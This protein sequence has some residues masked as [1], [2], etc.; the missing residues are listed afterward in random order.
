MYDEES[1]SDSDLNWPRV[2]KRKRSSVAKKSSGNRRTS[3]T[4]HASRRKR[5][6][7][8]PSALQRV[9]KR[10]KDQASFPVMCGDKQ[11]VLHKAKFIKKT[12][13]KCIRTQDAWLTPKDFLERNKVDGN[14]RR[15][16]R[17]RDKPLGELIMNGELELHS[18][19]CKCPICTRE[20]LHEVSAGVSQVQVLWESI[21]AVS[22]APALACRESLP[23]LVPSFGERGDDQIGQ[24]LLQTL[25][26]LS[27]KPK[28]TV[29]ECVLAM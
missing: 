29:S 22:L 23:N 2:G 24:V 17:R 16:I 11:G 3:Y 8:S 4:Q 19:N 20:L 7:I 14:W 15:D 1:W 9:G 26:V 18:V 10:L 28:R 25:E 5:F 12:C 27:V 13:G 6:R 21:A